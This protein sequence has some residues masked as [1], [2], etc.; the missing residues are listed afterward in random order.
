MRSFPGK[1]VLQQMSQM[2]GYAAARAAAH[3]R[4]YDLALF[5]QFMPPPDGGG[6]QFL[7]GL[8][9]CLEER[10]WRVEN[11]TISDTTRA[12]LINSFNFDVSRLR[13]LR[14]RGCRMV[15]RIDGPISTY[16]GFDDGTDQKV[17][18]INSDFAD[19][20]ILQSNYSLTKH[21][22]LGFEV[23]EARIICNAADPLIFHPQGRIQFDLNRKIRLVSTSWS[24]NLNKGAEIY[25]WLDEHLDWDR[26][27]YVFIGR[28][29][30]QPRHIRV[31]PP[32]SSQRVADLLRQ[33]DIYVTASR[34]DPCSN[35]LIEAMSCGLPSVCLRS[36]GHPE[37]LGQGGELFNETSEI[38]TLLD[39]ILSDYAGYQARLTPPRLEE[40]A[41]AYLDVMGLPPVPDPG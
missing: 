6:H 25:E 3:W 11:N 19:A 34:N 32:A 4:Q 40:V 17:W 22:E 8:V 21:R 37:L 5:H 7:R 39:W 20:T 16:R 10:Q 31:E 28:L 14:R 18:N 33:S 27:E 15:H 13:W 23:R 38:P 26:Y 30:L 2:A 24:D 35:S 12:C 29:P 36:G 9:R 41:T 1:G